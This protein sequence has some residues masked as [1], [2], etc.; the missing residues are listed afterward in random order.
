MSEIKIVMII[1]LL[2]F[3]SVLDIKRRQI[4]LVLTAVIGLVV[5]LV[6]IWERQPWGE[7]GLSLIP[8]VVFVLLAYV[9]EESIGYGDAWVL[10]SVGCYLSF[11]EMLTM[12]M[13]ALCLAG[14]TALFLYIFLYKK[15]NY[16]MPFIPFL[17]IGYLSMGGFCA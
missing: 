11:K 8:G 6:R 4:S 2:G 16:E 7:L 9:T 3:N 5:I 14:V 13:S 15:K 10:L 17:F 1:L 12:C